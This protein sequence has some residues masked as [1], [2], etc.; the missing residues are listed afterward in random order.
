MRCDVNI[1]LENKETGEQANR[2]EIKNVLGIR[3]IEK[4]IE[5]EV[6]RQAK[7]IDDGEKVV[8]ETRR[9]DAINDRTFSLR[10]KE[11]DI[12]YRFLGE[13]DIPPVFISDEMVERVAE[14][15]APV[16]FEQKVLMSEELGMSIEQV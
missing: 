9:Y 7:L 12:D 2:V 8:K 5:Y 1:S 11:E 3:F 15:M 10:T 13:P 4:A 16:P 6:Q 14:S